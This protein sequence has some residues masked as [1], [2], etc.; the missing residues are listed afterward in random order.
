VRYR[1]NVTAGGA[2][3]IPPE[4]GDGP[5]LSAFAISRT[6]AAAQDVARRVQQAGFERLWIPE[7]VRPVFS[8]CTASALAARD[9]AHGTGVAVAFAR[10]PMVSAQAAWMLAEET[11]G[12]FVLGLGSQVKAHVER[13]YSAPFAKPGPRMR[14]YVEAVRAIF[15]AFRGAPLS[16]HGT[17]YDFSLLPGTWSPGPM[18]WPDPPVYVAGVRPWMCRMIGEVADGML[19]HP[20]NSARYLRDVVMPAVRDG[21]VK[22]GRTE[23]EVALVCPVM[24]AVS[25][26]EQVLE[27]QRRSIRTRLAFYGSTP[28]Y[29]VAFD[30][31]GWRGLGEQ[32]NRLQRERQPDRMAALITDDVVDAFSISST[33]DELPARLMGRYGGIAA[34]VVCYSAVEH[35]NDDPDSLGRWQDVNRRFRALAGT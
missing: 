3:R 17:Y 28:G 5:V 24:T 8:V 33:W 34:D 27:R 1:A 11:G 4:A 15:A 30:A 20:L 10:S 12:R 7:S 2:D 18:K 19:V 29:G 32:L 21:E 35:W 31:S 13:R 6:A 9:L 25:D 16:Y 14:E 22:A 23:G 26:D